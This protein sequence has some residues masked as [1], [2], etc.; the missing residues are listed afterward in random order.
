MHSI[1]AEPPTIQFH[2][3]T[4][5]PHTM[6]SIRASNEL[7]EIPHVTNRLQTITFE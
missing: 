6:F 5:V 3:S 1:Q 4:I 7:P 2:H